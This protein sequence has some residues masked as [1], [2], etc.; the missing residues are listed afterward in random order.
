MAVNRAEEL[1]YDVW[2]QFVLPPFFD[3]LSIGH[4]RKPKVIIGGRGCGKT[5]LLRYLAHESTFSRARAEIPKDTLAHIGLY[6]RA[7]TQFASLMQLRDIPDDTWWAAFKHMAAIILGIEL[8]R[9]LDSIAHSNVGIIREAEL[10]SINCEKLQGFAND[11]PTTLGALR[12]HLERALSGFEVWVND[13]RSTAQPVFLPGVAFLKMMIELIKEQLPALSGATFFVYIDEYENL[14]AYQQRIINTWLKHSEP[15]LVF[16]LAMK[17]NGFKT[18]ATEGDEALSD[19]HDYR[20]IDLE[21]FDS[22]SDFQVFAAEILLLRLRLAGQKVAALKIDLLRDPELLATRREQKYADSVRE[23]AR[24]LFPQLSHRELA[25]AA[26]GDDQLRER[27]KDRISKALDKRGLAK[28]EAAAFLPLQSPEAAIIIPALLYRE[29]TPIS[30]V[31]EELERLSKD[32]PNRFT[33]PANWNHNNFVGC[34][35]QLFDGLPRP[36]PLFGGF[37]TYC[38]MSRGN[39]RH[40]LELCHKA[41]ERAPKRNE[42][43]KCVSVETQADAARLVASD[44]LAEIRSFGVKGNNLHAF[45]LR[46]GSLFALSQQQP[47]QSEPE[48]THF[49]IQG[50]GDLGSDEVKFLAEAVKWS[51]LFE[52]KGTKKKSESEPEGIEYVL[53]P[54]YAPYFHISYRKKRRLEAP[55]EHVAT[56]ISGSYEA[57]RALLR[58]YERRWAIS[59]SEV[60]LPLFS[61]MVEGGKSDT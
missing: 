48:R 43:V 57:V 45:V 36:C 6:W 28:D 34:Y 47:T 11:I 51:V 37:A 58:D 46:L 18:R 23:S 30:V 22:D 31:K 40:F 42:G 26:V 49:V 44:L 39:I 50:G 4:T 60:S 16:N 32:L 21:S 53:N 2:E 3:K 12:V 41:L 25:A 56:L 9:S 17:R 24:R 61:H 35:L 10:P 38:Y 27:L 59:L 19:I 8:L 33:G 20:D 7:D 54:I 52:E 1:G 5:M 13:I 55:A 14:A 15:P 29:S